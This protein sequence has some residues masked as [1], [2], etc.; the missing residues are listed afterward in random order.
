MFSLFQSKREILRRLNQNLKA[1][2]DGKGK[3]CH[4]DTCEV[5]VHEDAKGHEKE[6]SVSSDRKKWEAGGQLVIPLDESAWDASFSATDS[7][8][9]SVHI[10]FWPNAHVNLYGHSE[11]KN[12]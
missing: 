10:L 9:K 5:I 6:K 2:E 12:T 4:S 1:Q 8:Y 7:G 11:R 3:Q